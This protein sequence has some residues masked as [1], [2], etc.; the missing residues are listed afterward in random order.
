VSLE[1]VAGASYD[2]GARGQKF[3]PGT[4]K[5]KMQDRDGAPLTSPSEFLNEA[6][7]TAIGLCLYLAG[8]SR[9]VPPQR[10]DG[11]RYPRLLVLDDVLLSLD[12]VHRMP[13]LNV[14]KSSRF[15]EWQVLM[16]T[17]DR[18]WYEI[19]KQE[20]GGDKWAHCELF[21]RRVGD[22]D[23]P[24]VREDHDH[25]LQAIDFLEAGH[26][27]AAAVHVRTRFEEVLKSACTRLEL[28]VRYQPDP[29]RVKARD[30]WD[31]VS[32]ATW[33][34]IPSVRHATDSK[35]KLRWWQP[36]ARA[37]AV[38][39]PKLKA[40]IDHALTWV[41]NPLS[42]SQGV[43]G[44]RPEI[45]DAIFAVHELEQAVATA[46]AMRQAGPV[47]LRQMLLGHL[48]ARYFPSP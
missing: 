25:L 37:T 17:H 8:M 6:R 31:A 14:L 13:L 29:R 43:D 7:I 32:A 24:L 35:G 16:L 9:S 39:P 42:H 45:E 18:S 20:L 38:V 3:R 26:V 34:D 12:M 22:Y 27:K 47:V 48:A 44:Y 40:R 15:T 28:R 1:W 46:L 10:T 21:A 23:Q 4:V 19:A 11:S 41:M 2:S 30:F 5:L 33:D 36:E